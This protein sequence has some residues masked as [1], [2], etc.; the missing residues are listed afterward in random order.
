MKVSPTSP[1][2]TWAKLLPKRKLE[3]LEKDPDLLPKPTLSEAIERAIS[4]S[5]DTTLVTDI[6]EKDKNEAKNDKTEHENVK[7][8][9]SQSQKAKGAELD[10]SLIS[11]TTKDQSCKR[12]IQE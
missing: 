11:L 8:V 10:N 9:K 5:T 3:A 7:S 4:L 2:V 6:H 1:P 12:T